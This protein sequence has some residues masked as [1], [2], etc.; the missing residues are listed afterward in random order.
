MS[1]VTPLVLV[2]PKPPY[3]LPGLVRMFRAGVCSDP[4]GG[5]QLAAFI[6]KAM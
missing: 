4:E 6:M 1:E 3:G 5:G 2:E